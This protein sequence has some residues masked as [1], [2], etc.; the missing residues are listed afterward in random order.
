MTKDGFIAVQKNPI[1]DEVDG[2]DSLQATTCRN[3]RLFGG[4][5]TFVCQFHS[6]TALP[7]DLRGA[8]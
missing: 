2:R 4:S 8:M 6:F 1:G 3:L 7:G 5:L